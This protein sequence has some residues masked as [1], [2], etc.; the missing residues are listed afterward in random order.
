MSTIDSLPQGSSLWVEPESAAN[1]S[2][3][4]QYPYNNITQTESGHTF[5][6]D[7]TPGRERVRLQHRSGTFIEMH[8]NG[9]EVHK[10]YGDGYEITIKNKNVLIKGTCNLTIEGD[11]NIDVKGDKTERIQGNYFLEVR[12]EL[13][14]RC[15]E[16]MTLSSDADVQVSANENYDG[17]IFLS[18]SDSVTVASDV[19]VS[20]AVG[21]DIVTA[22]TRIDAGLGIRA[23]IYGVNSL[24][25]I[26][27]TVSVAAPIATFGFSKAILAT[28]VVNKNIYS[29][30]VHP[31]PKG[32]TGL[33]KL[34]QI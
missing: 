28:D 24:G 25:P 1:T 21:A 5:E 14:V 22:E 7:D 3:P 19:A 33:P 20:G 4:P 30:H 11:L 9:N 17:T 27:S 26:I 16:D 6:L 10:V 23:G 8:P 13:N 31:I 2:N 15:V 32:F 34:K 18:A 29:F 12:K